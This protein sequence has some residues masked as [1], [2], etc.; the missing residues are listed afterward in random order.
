MGHSGSGKTTLTRL[1]D[2]L[3]DLNGGD[4]LF[5]DTSIKTIDIKSLRENVAIVSQD[6]F[7]IDGSIRD[8]VVYGRQDASDDDV[9]QVLKLADLADFVNGLSDGLDTQVGERGVKLSG[10]QKQRL[11]IARALLK[12]APIIILDEATASLDNE[13]EKAIQHA[14]DN[15]L[16]SRTALVIAHRLST[17]HNADQ[18]VVLDDGQVVET[19]NHATL[20]AKNGAYAALYNAQFE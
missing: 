18:I 14:L 4:I 7:V 8:N 11:S 6:V 20:M 19:G 1:I 10:G 17:I 12:D 9:L 13:S 15:L 2:R 3:Y 16:K 5:D